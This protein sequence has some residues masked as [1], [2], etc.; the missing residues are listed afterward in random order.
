MM[1][2]G[3]KIHDYSQGN[4]RGAEPQRQPVRLGGGS[5][6]G[7]LELLQEESEPRQFA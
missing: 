4:E 3:E 6:L 2:C 5:V 7:D 1:P